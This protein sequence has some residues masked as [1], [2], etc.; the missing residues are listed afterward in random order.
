MPNFLTISIFDKF[1][2]VVL[3]IS[4]RSA[5]SLGKEEFLN[6]DKRITDYLKQFDVDVRSCIGMNQVHEDHV[7][8]IDSKNKNQ[9]LLKTD[10]LITTEPDI[11]LMVKTADCLPVFFYE[12]NKKIIGVAH[13][14]WKGIFLDL[15]S[16]MIEKMVKLG[17]NI[18]DIYI[19]VGPFIHSCCYAVS[20]DRIDKFQEK[21]GPDTKI[22][23]KRKG[24]YYL[25]LQYLLQ[26]QFEKIGC[27]KQKIEFL[28]LCTSCNNQDF[29]SYRKGDRDNVILGIIGRRFYGRK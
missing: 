29:F 7:V 17:A 27:N 16:K 14:G 11:F 22:Y 3:K 23:Q 26:K 6:R 28:S 25:D 21:Y 8:I 19:G 1:E 18:E 15:G 10:G 5:E 12:P 4:K 20:K 2:E 9:F 24:K 13:L